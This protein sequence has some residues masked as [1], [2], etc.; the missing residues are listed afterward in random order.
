METKGMCV[1]NEKSLQNYSME[2][3][4]DEASWEA[5]AQLGE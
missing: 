1:G 5:C 3:W 2:T 4:K